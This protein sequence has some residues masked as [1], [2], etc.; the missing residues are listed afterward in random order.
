VSELLER[1]TGYEL[2]EQYIAERFWPVGEPARTKRTI[3]GSYIT[4]AGMTGSNEDIAAANR[5]LKELA[6]EADP[7]AA[8]N[9]AMSAGQ[10]KAALKSIFKEN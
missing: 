10:I 2:A 3:M 4:R 5:I 6:G 7:S 9:K 1:H 8:G